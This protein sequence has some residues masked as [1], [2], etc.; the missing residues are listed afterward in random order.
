MILTE[1]MA[2]KTATHSMSVNCF[3]ADASSHFT[4]FWENHGGLIRFRASQN[5][6]K[7]TRT[8]LFCHFQIRKS[9][10]SQNR[11]VEPAHFG[12]FVT[13]LFS[14]LCASVSPNS[15]PHSVLQ[16]PANKIQQYL[17]MGNDALRFL[18]KNGSTV[19]GRKVTLGS[20]HGVSSD[21]WPALTRAQKT[22]P[23]PSRHFRR[24]WTAVLS[25]IPI[26]GKAK[27]FSTLGATMGA[28]FDHAHIK[29]I[30][31]AI[32]DRR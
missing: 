21:N 28:T 9:F 2:S 3:S 16:T 13:T 7:A 31:S 29:S 17:K 4:C 20:A 25:R 11:S 14:N 19:Q 18:P 30:N 1:E 15:S 5:H 24:R 32:F 23:N 12:V 27:Y 6:Q 26:R 22:T 10:K 8:A